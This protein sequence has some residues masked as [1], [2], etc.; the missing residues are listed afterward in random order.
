MGPGIQSY[1]PVTSL[2]FLERDYCRLDVL[3]TGGPDGT[4]TM[5]TWNADDTPEGEKA[6]WQF[7][8][9]RE[10]KV[11]GPDGER[12]ARGQASVVTALKFVGYA[13]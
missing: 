10:L 13:E 7:R 6:R 9:L 12:Q 5:R 1:P 3:A 11:K 8:T 4:I 2:A